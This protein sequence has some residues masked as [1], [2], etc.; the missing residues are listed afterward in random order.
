MKPRYRGHD[1]LYAMA[2]KVVTKDL[3]LRDAAQQLSVAPE[4][5]LERLE[6]RFPSQYR[7]SPRA[8]IRRLRGKP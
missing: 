4:W 1:V 3:R 6:M 2:G 5:V 7:G 8:L